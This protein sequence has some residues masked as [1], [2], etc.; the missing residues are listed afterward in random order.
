L[1][2]TTGFKIPKA[3]R[4][5]TTPFHFN[6]LTN[7]DILNRL[8]HVSK[9]ERLELTD[10]DLKAL[11]RLARYARGDMRMALNSLER[12]VTPDHHLD[13]EGLRAYFRSVLVVLHWTLTKLLE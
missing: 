1:L 11:R 7:D 9:A 12:F 4:S 5:R 2:A 13:I 8:I 3:N 6:K 10:P